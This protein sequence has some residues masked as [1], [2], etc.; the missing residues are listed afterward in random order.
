MRLNTSEGIWDLL[1]KKVKTYNQNLLSLHAVYSTN[2]DS[3]ITRISNGNTFL[4]DPHFERANT[5]KI[6]RE[7]TAQ[8][9]T[10]EKDKKFLAD[11]VKL[12]ND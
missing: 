9:E 3:Y 6:D 7:L 1:Q 12:L 4:I 2:E 10:D 5:T 11:R 8:L